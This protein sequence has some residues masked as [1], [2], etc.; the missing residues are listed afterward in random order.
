MDAS[1][2]WVVMQPSEPNKTVWVQAD[3]GLL[4]PPPPYNVKEAS[5]TCTGKTPGGRGSLLQHL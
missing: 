2:L 1:V 3:L 5:V 4:P